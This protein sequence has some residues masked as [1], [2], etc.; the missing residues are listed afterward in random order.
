M[1]VFALFVLPNFKDHRVETIR[2]PADGPI[3]LGNIGA[4]IEVIG[5]GENLLYFLKIDSAFGI[6]P[7]LLALPLCQIGIASGI[8]VILRSPKGEAMSRDASALDQQH[9]VPFSL[10]IK[11]FISNSFPLTT[12]ICSATSVDVSFGFCG[13]SSPS[14]TGTAK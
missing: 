1:K 11:A 3:L 4:L 9:F 2:Y 7:Q 14:V 13:G 6:G 8:A 10:E 5:M 12:R